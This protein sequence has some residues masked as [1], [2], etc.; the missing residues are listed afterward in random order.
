MPGKRVDASGGCGAGLLPR[1]A[2]SECR[3]QQA[4]YGVDRS[5]GDGG[6]RAE[7]IADPVEVGSET[8]RGLVCAATESQK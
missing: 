4:R 1:A 8:G 3:H 2:P 5:A 7:A 6:G